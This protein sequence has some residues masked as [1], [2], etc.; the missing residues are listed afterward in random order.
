MAAPYIS[1]RIFPG[2]L[3]TFSPPRLVHIGI[4]V[5]DE[6]FL[7]S[8]IDPWGT[9]GGPGNSYGGTPRATAPDLYYLL[10]LTNAP[11]NG[12]GDF[13]DTIRTAALLNTQTG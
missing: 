6:A 3:Y 5:G 12:P 13:A 9:I 4:G 1:P 7:R 11:V 8:W 10:A 2:H